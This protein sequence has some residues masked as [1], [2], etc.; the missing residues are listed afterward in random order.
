MKFPKV[1]DD[2]YV[3]GSKMNATAKMGARLSIVERV[4]AYKKRFLPSFYEREGN[5]ITHLPDPQVNT[6]TYDAKFFKKIDEMFRRIGGNVQDPANARVVF[7]GDTH[8][9][10]YSHMYNEK[11]LKENVKEGDIILVEG[12][13]KGQAVDR[14]K[15]GLLD[16]LP[17]SLR[18]TVLGWDN[19]RDRNQAIAMFQEMNS[20]IAIANQALDSTEIA[21]LENRLNVLQAKT[22][23]LMIYKRNESLVSAVTDAAFRTKGKIYVI[24]GEKH[25]ETLD[26]TALPSMPYVMLEP[27]QRIQEHVADT[28]RVVVRKEPETVEAKEND[29]AEI[30]WIKAFADPET[31]TL[32]TV[33]TQSGKEETINIGW[34]DG[35]YKV[36]GTVFISCTEDNKTLDFVKDLWE[37]PL[38]IKTIES[39][40]EK[41][42][43]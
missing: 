3:E 23:N 20:F 24:A 16:L 25:L 17:A 29:E 33:L 32:V 26:M 43:S 28:A 34:L 12:Y 1:F 36:G 40:K 42:W 21:S 35:D 2:I 22:T 9:S 38:I 10:N 13:E 18:I 41:E 19:T 11:F 31:I 7:L 39:K 6:R 14:S 27:Y 30:D 15:V 4:K 8:T 5:A 37:Q